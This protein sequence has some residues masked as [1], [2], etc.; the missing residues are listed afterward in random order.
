MSYAIAYLQIFVAGSCA[1]VCA[2]MLHSRIHG[3]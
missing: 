3:A 2:M 1:I